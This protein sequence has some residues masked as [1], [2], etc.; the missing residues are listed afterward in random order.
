MHHTALDTN[1]HREIADQADRA[2]CQ[3]EL[4]A[5]FGEYL[6]ILHSYEAVDR[7]RTEP[8]RSPSGPRYLL[9]CA[10]RPGWS[11]E[12]GTLE[13]AEERAS[14]LGDEG[15][16][17]DLRRDVAGRSCIVFVLWVEV[18]GRIHRQRV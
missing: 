17:V 6:S 13:E 7:A 1:I 5:D 18:G 12:V 14:E 15:G 11:Y 3:H 16:V 9:T 10:S 8:G 4:E 2:A